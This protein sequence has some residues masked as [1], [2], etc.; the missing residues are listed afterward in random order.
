MH[1]LQSDPGRYL[2]DVNLVNRRADF[3]HTPSNEYFLVFKM[4]L[5]VIA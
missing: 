2:T 1:S 4:E 3:I 5:R